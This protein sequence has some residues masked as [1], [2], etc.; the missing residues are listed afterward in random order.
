MKTMNP[1]FADPVLQSQACFRAVLE[2]MA[3][4]GLIRRVADGP[5]APGLDPVTAAVLLS[6]VDQDTPLYLDPA[7]AGAADWLR[8]HAG[9]PLVAAG[10]AAFALVGMPDFASFGA[11]SDEAPEEGATVLV[12]VAALGR[13]VPCRL[14]GPG[15]A[16][17]GTLW[18]EGLPDAFVQD[19][20]GN[21]RLFPRGVDVILCAGEQLAALPRTVMIEAD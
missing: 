14:T 10:A 4:P 11:G 8:F 2:A 6:L 21:A 15:L 13:G 5:D 12:Q 3:R 1:G 18:V 9:V 16:A 7:F 19:W 17:P 20:A